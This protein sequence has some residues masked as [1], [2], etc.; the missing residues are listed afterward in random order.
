VTKR[1]SA[2]DK[3]RAETAFGR[4]LTD[5]DAI[6]GGTALAMMLEIIRAHRDKRSPEPGAVVY[7]GTMFDAW[8]MDQ[9]ARTLDELLELTGTK[10]RSPIRIEFKRDLRNLLYLENMGLLVGAGFSVEEAASLIVEHSTGTAF[11]KLS[12]E[13]LFSPRALVD[14]FEKYGG[15][16]WAR[17]AGFFADENKARRD[18]LLKGIPIELLPARFR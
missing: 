18:E 2:A 13:A 11:K 10:G 15:A 17:E 6:R 12:Q 16:Q 14:L 7:W 8:I 3:A 4:L 9:E 1:K 5:P